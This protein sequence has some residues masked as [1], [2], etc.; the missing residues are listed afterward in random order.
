[1]DSNINPNIW[2]PDQWTVLYE[3]CYCFEHCRHEKNAKGMTILKRL[4][5]IIA[6][7]FLCEHCGEFFNKQLVLYSDSTN[8]IDWIYDLKNLVTLKIFA[9]NTTHKCTL[10]TCPNI[11]LSRTEFYDRLLFQHEKPQRNPWYKTINLIRSFHNDS[12]AIQDL[13]T[14]LQ[15]LVDNIP[16]FSDFDFILDNHPDDT[17]FQ[18]YLKA[19]TIQ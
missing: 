13:N 16:Y 19:A 12:Y 14:T 9:C 15:D 3:I 8:L 17:F 7:L 6:N 4:L 2:G 5:F 10:N 18:N 1:M 11:T